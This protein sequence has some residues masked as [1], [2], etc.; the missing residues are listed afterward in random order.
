MHVCVRMHAVPTILST[1]S[2]ES[3]LDQ[4]RHKRVVDWQT[5]GHTVQRTAIS[6]QLALTASCGDGDERTLTTR[7]R[8]LRLEP[9]P[10]PRVQVQLWRPVPGRDAQG[11]QG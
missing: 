2:R 6:T 1:D 10:P 11:E 3:Q 7:A 4:L 9:V 8:A 5:R